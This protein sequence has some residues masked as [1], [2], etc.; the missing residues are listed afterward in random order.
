MCFS[1]VVLY[2]FVFGLAHR[3]TVSADRE[4]RNLLGQRGSKRGQEK[5]T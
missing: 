2:G 1:P 5:S 3:V 4:L